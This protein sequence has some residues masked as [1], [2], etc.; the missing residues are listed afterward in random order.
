MLYTL[1]N[2]FV[3]LVMTFAIVHVRYLVLKKRLMPRS[4][5]ITRTEN[6]KK[7][8]VYIL[9][10]NMI[11]KTLQYDNDKSPLIDVYRYSILDYDTWDKK[12]NKTEKE[13]SSGI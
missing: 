5:A 13:K 6:W 12:L 3:K 7:P 10:M 4:S 8:I 11:F 1:V 9:F 2:L